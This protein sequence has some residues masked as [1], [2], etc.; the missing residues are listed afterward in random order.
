MAINGIT[1]VSFPP[2]TK[3]LVSP[4]YRDDQGNVALYPQGKP[5]GKYR[6]IG[7]D[8]LA[9]SRPEDQTLD[10]FLW[11]E[12]VTIRDTSQ[13]DPSQDLSPLGMIADH[14]MRVE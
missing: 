14:F 2:G 7:D 6:T 12:S 3:G 1:Y 11:G 10:Y 5:Y 8:F 9:L 4:P 13:G